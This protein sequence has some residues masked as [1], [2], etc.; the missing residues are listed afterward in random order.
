MNFTYS[1]CVFGL[2]SILFTTS[3]S[4]CRGQSELAIALIDNV[5]NVTKMVQI[6][7]W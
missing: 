5:T 2:L 3:R 1:D 6:N 7:N 4:A